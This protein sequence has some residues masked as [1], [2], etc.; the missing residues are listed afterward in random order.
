MLSDRTEPTERVYVNNRFSMIT[1]YQCRF[2]H[3]NNVPTLVGVSI[4]GI[5]CVSVEIKDYMRCLCTFPFNFA[6][7]SKLLYKSDLFFKEVGACFLLFYF[8]ERKK[9]LC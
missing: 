7:N 5:D 2:I 8:L 3:C 6:G 1:L 9:E 4:V